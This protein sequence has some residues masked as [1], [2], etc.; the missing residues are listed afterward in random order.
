M[1]NKITYLIITS[2]LVM[3]AFLI[4]KSTAPKQIITKTAINSIQLE[5]AIP[6]SDVAC[7]YVKDGYITV[8]LKDV[9]RQLDD[10]AN[11]SYT[12]V[13]K[14]I[15]NETITYRNNMIDISKVTDFTATESKLQ[16]Y[17]EDG[18]GYYWER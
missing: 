6:L 1:K 3:S 12:D 9:T 11:A 10:K 16:I 4:G 18:S 2:A 15:P 13:L 7:W 5:K 17:L 8:E 14:D